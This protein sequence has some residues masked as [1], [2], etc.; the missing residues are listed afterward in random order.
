MQ[1]TWVWSLV[2]NYGSIP[3]Q[4]SPW[5]MTTEPEH[6]SSLWSIHK[7]AHMLQ[8]QKPAHHNKEPTCLDEDQAQPKYKQK[9]R[10]KAEVGARESWH[11]LWNPVEI[12][13]GL[14]CLGKEKGRAISMTY[15]STPFKSVSRL[16]KFHWAVYLSSGISVVEG[17]GIYQTSQVSIW[18]PFLVQKQLVWERQKREYRSRIYILLK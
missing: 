16:A 11:F 8:I 3:G 6:P 9:A 15:P 7:R 2:G 13:C 1:G 17:S 18:A 4:L 12:F 10:D 14:E 5:P